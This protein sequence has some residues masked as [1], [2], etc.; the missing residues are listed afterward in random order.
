MQEQSSW[1]GVRE[2]WERGIQDTS[3]EAGHRRKQGQFIHCD[4]GGDKRY[5]GTDAFLTMTY[6]CSILLQTFVMSSLWAGL[7]A[8]THTSLVYP[9]VSTQSTFKYKWGHITSLLKTAE[10]F[11]ISLKRE[12]EVLHDL[13][14]FSSCFSLLLHLPL[15]PLHIVI[16]SFCFSLSI[17]KHLSISGTLNLFSGTFF[18]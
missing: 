9:T 18:F 10:C 3:A 14:L 17:P 11:P 12:A 8:P 15:S 16:W 7:L 4:T 13:M 5:G 2:R 6:N 1:E